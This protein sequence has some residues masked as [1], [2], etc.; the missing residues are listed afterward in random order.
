MTM[1]ARRCSTQTSGESQEKMPE[2]A[3]HAPGSFYQPFPAARG[4]PP[5]QQPCPWQSLPPGSDPRAMLG[6]C[7]PN[8]GMMPSYGPPPT[9]MDASHPCMPPSAHQ[10]PHSGPVAAQCGSHMPPPIADF[11]PQ[12]SYP[13]TAPSYYETQLSSSTYNGTSACMGQMALP[14]AGPSADLRHVD[15]QVYTMPGSNAHADLYPH[16]YDPPG[17]Q[18]QLHNYEVSYQQP[19][20]SYQQPEVAASYP[21]QPDPYAPHSQPYEQPAYQPAEQPQHLIQQPMPYNHAATG[22]ILPLPLDGWK[23]VDPH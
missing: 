23:S 4:P 18:P 21:Y 14:Q 9:G 16:P 6:P 20:V 22:L 13:T 5:H 12:S 10:M 2:E 11:Q 8:L 17:S 15:H 1:T 3:S 19:E 7:R